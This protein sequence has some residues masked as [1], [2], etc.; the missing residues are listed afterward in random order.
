MKKRLIISVL[1]LSCI[2]SILSNQVV[3]DKDT[4]RPVRLSIFV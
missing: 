2:G 1:F 4:G 3:V